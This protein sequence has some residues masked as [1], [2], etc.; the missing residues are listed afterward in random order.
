MKQAIAILIL[1][2]TCKLGF[3]QPYRLFEPVSQYFFE[4]TAG[5]ENSLSDAIRIDSVEFI[6]GVGTLY[7]YKIVD[8]LDSFG[9]QCSHDPFQMSWVGQKI[10][11]LP[12]GIFY[13][14]NEDG[15]TIRIES[16][17]GLGSQFDVFDLGGGNR[18]V[19][20]VTFIGPQMVLGFSDTVKVFQLTAR[21]AG[22][23]VVSHP[24]NQKEF[25]LG[26]QL[27]MVQALRFRD[28]PNDVTELPLAGLGPL[29]LGRVNIGT[30]EIYDWE[31]GDTFQYRK[32]FNVFNQS[33]DT[34]LEERVILSKTVLGDTVRYEINRRRWQRS[35]QFMPPQDNVVTSNATVTETYVHPAAQRALMPQEFGSLDAGL[36]SR[37]ATAENQPTLFW[38]GDYNGRSQKRFFDLWS[39]NDVDSCLE[40][41][42]SFG[43]P[44]TSDYAEEVGLVYAVIDDPFGTTNSTVLCYY[45]KGGEVWGT[46][47]DFDLLLIRDQEVEDVVLKVYPN[48]ARSYIEVQREGSLSQLKGR[49]QVVDLAGALVREQELPIGDNVRVDLEGLAPGMYGYVIQL[50]EGKKSVGKLVV[51]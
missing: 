47:K 29:N 20:E 50:G 12:A 26:E 36:Q 11:E 40:L 45:N 49:I 21:D 32:V 1:L 38:D 8:S 28:F 31:V 46:R 48:P 6:G 16:F 42:P 9:S 33:R 44:F 14:F 5:T 43:I 23:N 4:S 2:L 13:L 30:R 3:A 24:M 15:D 19:A 51:R 34:T 35:I 22:G 37:P 39:Y 18:L 10:V 7:N 25:H 41:P 27:G 17:A